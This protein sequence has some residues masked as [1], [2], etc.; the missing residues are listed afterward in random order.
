MNQ[1]FVL[2]K[3]CAFDKLASATKLSIELIFM[4]QKIENWEKIDHGENHAIMHFAGSSSNAKQKYM[5]IKR[6][7]NHRNICL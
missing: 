7:L 4:H 1:Y 2:N 5:F 6:Y 3:I